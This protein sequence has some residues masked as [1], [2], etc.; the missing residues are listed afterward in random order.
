MD[1]DATRE[2]VA[3]QE[4]CQAAEATLRSAPSGSEDW[5]G[6]G[7]WTLGQLVGHLAGAAGRL[8]RFDRAEPGVPAEIDR[9]RYYAES[10]GGSRFEDPALPTPRWAES[11]SD[12]W[13]A[14]VDRYRELGDDAVIVSVAGPIRAVEYLATRVVEVVVHHADVR[15]ALDLPPVPTVEAEQ[16][17]QAVLEGLLDGP[18]PRNLGRIRFILAATGRLPFDDPR[19]PVL[20]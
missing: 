3:F 16:I 4:E 18:R 10:P 19:F 11:F 2:L 20:R 5:P 14:T 15:A 6:I 17:T 8:P 12:A 1:R 7:D 13:R 9:I